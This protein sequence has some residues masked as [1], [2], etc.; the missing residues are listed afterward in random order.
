[1]RTTLLAALLPICVLV[2]ACGSEPDAAARRGRL[3]LWQYG[4]GTCHEIKGVV[5]AVGK[6]GPPLN[7]L[8][9]RVYIAG[10]LPNTPDNLARWIRH[11]R[12]F[13]PRTGMPDMGVSE[14]QVRDMVTFLHARE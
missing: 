6:V 4:C 13:D 3:L 11:P 9:E 8:K 14:A 5:G 2:T 1:L 12:D 10:L 7:G